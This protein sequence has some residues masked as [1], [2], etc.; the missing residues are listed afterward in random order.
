MAAAIYGI[1]NIKIT[2]KIK[3]IV[4]F[5]PT[6]QPLNLTVLLFLLIQLDL[7]ILTADHGC[8]PATPSTDHS[9]EYVPLL[10]YGTKV[11]PGVDLGT[12]MSFACIAQTVCEYL[13]VSASALKG[14]SLLQEVKQGTI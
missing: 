13:G 14:K 4:I 2:S 11:R 7:L 3:R 10:M 5:T 6:F 1:A 12:R 9:R 8:D